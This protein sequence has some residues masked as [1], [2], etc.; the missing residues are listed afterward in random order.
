M[1]QTRFGEV[2]W[3][4]WKSEATI[5]QL[6]LARNIALVN[7]QCAEEDAD[8]GS[9]DDLDGASR[10]KPTSNLGTLWASSMKRLT[11]FLK[12]PFPEDHGVL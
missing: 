10:S 2:L 8:E 6:L 3:H 5:V 9:L 1:L 12:V 11:S 7:L 4:G